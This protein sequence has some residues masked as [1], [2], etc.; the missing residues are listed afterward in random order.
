MQKNIVF[1]VNKAL[2][3]EGENIKKQPVSAVPSEEINELKKDIDCLKQENSS[4]ACALEEV[5]LQNEELKNKIDQL[6]SSSSSGSGKKKKKT[7]KPK[8]RK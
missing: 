3:T 2:A 7:N 4:I 5:R 6:I 8:A 1:N